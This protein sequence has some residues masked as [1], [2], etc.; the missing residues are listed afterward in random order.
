MARED[1]YVKRWKVPSSSDASKTYTVALKKDGSYACSCPEW[2][3][4]RRE[5]HHIRQVKANPEGGEEFKP[6][7][8]VMAKVCEVTKEGEKILVPLVPLDR[9]ETTPF[10]A[11]I[12]YDC[13]KL[14]I[15]FGQLKEHYSI[16]P[17]DWTLEQV[18][19]YVKAHGRMV[20]VKGEGIPPWDFKARTTYDGIE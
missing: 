2:I 1:Q 7:V 9:A 3:Y 6:L 5:C 15:P 19:Q 17:S 11:T 12:V 10:L 16:M 4:R 14:G 18:K 8:M 20:Q 13:N